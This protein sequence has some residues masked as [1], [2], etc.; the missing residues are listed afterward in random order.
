MS[1]LVERQFPA[2]SLVAGL[3]AMG[4]SFSTAVA[5]IMDNSISA[6]ATE[7][8]IFSDPLDK[9]PYFCIL[10]NGFGMNAK[11]LDNAM[12]PGS[13]RDGKEILAEY[14]AATYFILDESIFSISNLYEREES[15]WTIYP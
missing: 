2:R 12:L 7:I 14:L 13:D 3:R 15:Q 5:D 10:D 8:R 6:E 4:Y 11:E 1:E 9:T